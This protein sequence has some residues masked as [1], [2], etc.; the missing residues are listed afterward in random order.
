MSVSD[1]AFAYFVGRCDEA[2][3][4]AKQERFRPNRPTIRRREYDAETERLTQFIRGQQ[5]AENNN[6]QRTAA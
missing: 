1:L 2:P 6:E 3:W 5:V 4:K